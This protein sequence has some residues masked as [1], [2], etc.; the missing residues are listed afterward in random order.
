MGETPNQTALQGWAEA[1][2][3]CSP[4]SPAGLGQRCSSYRRDLFSLCRRPPPRLQEVAASGKAGARSGGRSSGSRTSASA[5]SCERAWVSRGGHRQPADGSRRGTGSWPRRWHGGRAAAARA[6]HGAWHI[7]PSLAEQDYGSL[8]QKQPIGRLLFRQ[9]C[10]TRPELLRCIRFLDA[11]V[12]DPR[13]MPPYRLRSGTVT[14]R[15][16]FPGMGF[17]ESRGRFAALAPG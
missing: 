4:L 16:V 13:G 2:S 17:A 3:P 14:R 15:G 11:V 9:F 7:P 6:R 12:R 10:E 5:M 1:L 8:C